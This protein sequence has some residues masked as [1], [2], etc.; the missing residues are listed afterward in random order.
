MKIAFAGTPEFSSNLLK[1]LLKSHF[2]I[3][4]VYTQPARPKGRGLSISPSEVEVVARENNLLIYATERW[5]SVV[6]E[7]LKNS[8]AELLVTAAYGLII[9]NDALRAT[10]FGAINV[11]ASLL[12]QWRG[13]APIQRAIEAGDT[14]TGITIFQL[15]E[16]VD[17]GPI[18]SSV[19]TEIKPNETAVELMQRLEKIA[20]ELLPETIHKIYKGELISKSQNSGE[21]IYAKK[22]KKEEGNI[23][24]NLS[25]SEIHNKF[26]AFQPW[27]GISVGG[28]KLIS[29]SIS[30]Q[31]SKAGE[32]IS[33]NP[34]TIGTSNGSVIIEELQAPGR[35]KIKGIEYA[36]GKHLKKGDFFI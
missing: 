30:E 19:S 15:D 3:V 28:I 11:H 26:R 1:A 27:P 16:G 34:L 25:A 20:C 29:I 5:D 22:I 4:R 24:F 9:P 31:K 2:E 10:K 32:I 8:G 35:K 33:L 21:A 36:N 23:D 13:A 12:P 6:T 17:T 18:F 7:D 14:S